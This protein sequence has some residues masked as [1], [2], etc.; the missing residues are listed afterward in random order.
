MEDFL[1]TVKDARSVLYCKEGTK[2]FFKRY[3]LDWDKFV[4]VG[5][6]AQL[7]LDTG[8]AMAKEVVEVAHGR[9]GR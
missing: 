4:K 7:L 6:S 3:K 2:E 9:R 1:V 8:D 5:V